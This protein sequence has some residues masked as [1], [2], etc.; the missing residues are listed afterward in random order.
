MLING[1]DQ[2]LV[3]RWQRQAQL[4]SGWVYPSPEAY[5][6]ELTMAAFRIGIEI[7]Q[8][9][10]SISEN[11]FERRWQEYL[12]EGLH[13]LRN[14]REKFPLDATTN[15]RRITLRNLCEAM[16][17]N[18]A[19]LA[20]VPRWLWA[21]TWFCAA[22]FACIGG[23]SRESCIQQHDIFADWD[24]RTFFREDQDC[25]THFFGSSLVTGIIIFCSTFLIFYFSAV[26]LGFLLVAN[27]S[28]RRNLWGLHVLGDLIRS[29][30]EQKRNRPWI[31]PFRPENARAWI[32][33]RLVLDNF[34]LRFEKRLEIY[35]DTIFIV[36]VVMVLQ[37][38]I[39]FF[40]HSLNS[41]SK[42]PALLVLYGLWGC[43]MYS[44]P[45]LQL[46]ICGA[47][48]N[49]TFR[50]HRCSLIQQRMQ[51][52][53]LFKL[54]DELARIEQQPHSSFS[55]H[56]AGAEESG[57]GPVDE[58][59]QHQQQQQTRGGTSP[60]KRK[61]KP[62]PRSWMTNQKRIMAAA[63]VMKDPEKQHD[64]LV[65]TYEDAADMIDCLDQTS[66]A[67]VL[68]QRATYGLLISVLAGIFSALTFAF[69]IAFS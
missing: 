17:V 65:Q 14:P 22:V 3:R 68:R 59:K 10:L 25:S 41:G 4:I 32:F 18:S 69:E 37:L 39:V 61:K 20:R 63:S 9:E 57:E 38:M 55:T 64:E 7:D 16:I 15:C 19:S 42:L 33:A 48:I 46:L 36:V 49:D 47:Q 28:F 35:V 51:C 31:E 67:R 27:A 56:S 29:N 21:C 30:P 53:E 62:V 2:H 58:E 1:S 5:R 24:E 12:T 34:G 50:F 44:I 11:E 6:S 52:R 60:S 54:R 66:Y 23:L 40:R 45:M 43:A 26:T 8:V 13:G